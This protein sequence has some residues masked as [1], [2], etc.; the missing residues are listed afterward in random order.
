MWKIV[1]DSIREVKILK[2]YQFSKTKLKPRQPISVHVDI[3]KIILSKL[4]LFKAVPITFITVM[5][6][7]LILDREKFIKV[8]RIVCSFHLFKCALYRCAL[9]LFHSIFLCYA[10]SMSESIALQINFIFTDLT[11]QYHFL[12]VY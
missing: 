12:S 6:S 11:Q 2:P 1:L 8:I 9:L 5:S 3:T 10:T 7:F 4:G